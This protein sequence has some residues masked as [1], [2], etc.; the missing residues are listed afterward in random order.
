MLS[1]MEDVVETEI[2]SHLDTVVKEDV[3]NPKVNNF[4]ILFC[5][6]GNM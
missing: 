6:L 5:I 3:R 2:I 4:L 1:Y